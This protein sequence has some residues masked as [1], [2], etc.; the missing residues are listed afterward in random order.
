MLSP[1]SSRQCMHL[2]GGTRRSQAIPVPNVPSSSAASTPS[3]EATPVWPGRRALRMSHATLP[4]TRFGIS[5]SRPCTFEVPLRLESSPGSPARSVSS[6]VRHPARRGE[7]H[8][9]AQDRDLRGLPRS[10]RA[11]QAL[12]RSPRG[13]VR[14]RPLRFHA[15]LDDLRGHA[16]CRGRQRGGIDGMTGSMD[17]DCRRVDGRGT[18]FSAV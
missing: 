1:A 7:C 4:A 13:V 18:G 9:S 10:S 14:G 8:P 11:P 17:L 12:S 5:P 3:F 16:R 2:L 6:G 15:E